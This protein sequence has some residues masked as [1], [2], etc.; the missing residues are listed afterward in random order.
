VS[1][2]LR[3]KDA[4]DQAY[5]HCIHRSIDK[6]SRLAP[7]LLRPRFVVSAWLA[8][9][10]RPLALTSAPAHQIGT[11]TEVTASASRGKYALG[12]LHGELIVP[13]GVTIE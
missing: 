9:R 11:V 4:I 7:H 6:S 13:R 5:R 10:P 12:R 1:G 2:V 3:D 8:I